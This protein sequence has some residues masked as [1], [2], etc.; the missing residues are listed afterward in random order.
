MS[1][2]SQRCGP[3]LTT[4]AE[5]GK[6]DDDFVWIVGLVG[7]IALLV[8][9]PAIIALAVWVAASRWLAR[10]ELYALLG[11]GLLAWCLFA[12]DFIRGYGI[13]LRDLFTSSPF[14]LDS[15]PFGMLA[16]SVAVLLGIYGLLLSTTIGA[17][18]PKSLQ[19]QAP[20][21]R[22]TKPT[23][24]VPSAA[25]KTRMPTAQATGS[26]LISKSAHAIE[27]GQQVGKRKFP[28]GFGVNG[29]VVT[30]G[31][32][33]VRTHGVILG[34][35]GSGKSETIKSL[36]GALL[37]LGWS[38]M[39][40]D[41]KEDTAPGGLRDWCE[42]YAQVHSL[43]YQELALSDTDPDFWFNPL[44]GIGPDEIRD[45]ILS[46]N[47]FD[48]QH[49]QAINKELLGQMVN[50]AT[51]AHT[52]APDMFP[53]PT[54]YE[55]GKLL[56]GGSL[57]N[58]TKKMRA[59]VVSSVPGVT[60]D[61]F[62]ALA[63]PSPDHAK[64]A[65][66]FGSKLTGVYDT[67][68]GRTV[69]RAGEG[70]KRRAID[71]TAT[72]LVYVGL[73][74]LGKADLTK[75]VSSSILQR[76]SVYAAVR[77]SGSVTGSDARAPRFLIVDEANW[78]DR[79]IVQNLLSRARSAGIAMFLCTQGPEDWIDKDG[80]DWGRLSQNTNVAIIMRQGAPKSAELCADY[81]GTHVV[82][83]KRSSQQYTQTVFGQQRKVRDENFG[84]RLSEMEQ[85]L[86]EHIVPPETVRQLEI[87]EAVIKVGT[88]NRIEWCKVSMRDPAA[89]VH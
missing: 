23:T 55:L 51:Y 36:A 76:M 9:I 12:G 16:A 80:D 14:S 58:V 22:Q 38:G 17:K 59:V 41:L 13:L 72:G 62:R 43:P 53:A 35:T 81:L 44:A 49:W 20:V 8:S 29:T 70:G 87:G 79:T 33:E 24:V 15:I 65:G 84:T 18:V 78:V 32:D 2:P 30:L 3:T 5:K 74:S 67:Q 60:E 69:L 48:D 61:D 37:D 66:G 75:V 71:V 54:M 57:P 6:K 26:G 86:E 46:L 34:A 47:K 1:R 82:T 31:E 25:D 45:M 88:S 4:M 73:D 10:R 77:V 27:G 19:G 56:S 89:R 21:V 85:E 83:K 52:A 39:I 50:L 42:T 64:S 11:V 7:V 28:I 40:L 63:Q 68:A